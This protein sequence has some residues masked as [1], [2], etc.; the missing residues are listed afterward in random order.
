MDRIPYNDG[1]R[2]TAAWHFLDALIELASLGK[3]GYSK[4]QPTKLQKDLI[5]LLGDVYSV[6]KFYTQATGHEK[7]HSQALEVIQAILDDPQ[8]LDSKTR[9]L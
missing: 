7:L 9:L 3:A 5:G 1:E 8:A 2:A 6:Q 4:G